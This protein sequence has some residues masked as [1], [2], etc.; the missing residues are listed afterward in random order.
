MPR[1]EGVVPGVDL[2]NLV[3]RHVSMSVYMYNNCIMACFINMLL[4]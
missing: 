3:S 4:I 2:K 1:A